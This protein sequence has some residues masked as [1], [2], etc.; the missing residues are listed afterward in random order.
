L[1]AGTRLCRL[2]PY[3]SRK[4]RLAERVLESNPPETSPEWELLDLNAEPRQMKNLYYDQ[5]YA[6]VVRHVKTELDRLQREAG[7]SPV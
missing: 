4:C 7:D 3:R 2:F 5:K 6:P 1:F